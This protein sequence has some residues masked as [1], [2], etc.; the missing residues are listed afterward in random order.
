MS[1]YHRHLWRLHQVCTLSLASVVDSTDG[2][3]V[4]VQW[5]VSTNVRGGGMA[6]FYTCARRGMYI[7]RA[8]CLK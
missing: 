6:G 7:H 4:E 2:H 3:H 8:V 5:L 1:L